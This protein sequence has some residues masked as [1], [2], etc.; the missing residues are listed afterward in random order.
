MRKSK[1]CIQA[2]RNKERKE[3]SQQKLFI[4]EDNGKTSLKP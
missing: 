3:M 4:P 2:N 1:H